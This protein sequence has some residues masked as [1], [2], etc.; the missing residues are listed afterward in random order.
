MT[1]PNERTNDRTGLNRLHEEARWD[2]GELPVFVV[3][4]CR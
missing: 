1:L 2:R 3:P 4:W